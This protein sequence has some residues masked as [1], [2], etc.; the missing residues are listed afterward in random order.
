[1]NSEKVVEHIEKLIDEKFKVVTILG[2]KHLGDNKEFFL[3]ESRKK[4]ETL[5]AGLIEALKTPPP[6]QS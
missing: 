1:M 3:T 2:S 4:I 6:S 5:K